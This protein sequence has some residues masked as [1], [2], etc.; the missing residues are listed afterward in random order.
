[1]A[2][3][4]KKLGDA[5]SNAVST[6]K[7][8]PPDE[9]EANSLAEQQNQ[10]NQL[11]AKPTVESTVERPAMVANPLVRYGT[12]P[13]EVRYEV[14][15]H[16]NITPIQSTPAR[17]ASAP[18][19]ARVG[20][21]RQEQPAPSGLKPIIP[22]SLSQPMPYDQG[23]EKEGPPVRESMTV[24][25]GKPSSSLPPLVQE[26]KPEPTAFIAKS[27]PVYDKGGDVS[28][29]AA[30]QA[31]VAGDAGLQSRLNE[32]DEQAARPAASASP[33][34]TGSGLK[35]LGKAIGD[36]RA[37]KTSDAIGNVTTDT[38]DDVKQAAYMPGGGPAE[39]APNMPVM[40][41]ASAPVYDEGGDVDVN[42]G[43]HQAAILKEGEKVLTPEQAAQYRAEHEG[44]PVDFPGPVLPN[45]TGIKVHDSDNP[46]PKASDTDRLPKG[47]KA[48]ISNAPL[49][50]PQGDV[51]NPP[52]AD[53]QPSQVQNVSAR[54]MKPY[55]QVIE[56]RAKAKAEEK[57][58]SPGMQPIASES[59]E[60]QVKE[61]PPEERGTPQERAAIQK[62]KQ[63]A[64]G[65]G[66]DG[67]VKLG[68]ALIHQ[69]ALSPTPK[70]F[71]QGS[72]D[73]GTLEQGMAT[74][75]EFGQG[76]APQPG[77]KPIGGAPTTAAPPTTPATPPVPM[78][79]K[80]TLANY[81]KEIQA[82]M[83]QATPE[84]QERA[85]LLQKAKDNYL[86]S[87]PYGS[88][89]NH[90]GFLGKLGHVASK[91]GNIA[92]DV[93]APGVMAAIPGTDIYKAGGLAAHNQAATSAIDENT[94]RQAE[95]NKPEKTGTGPAT[96]EQVQDY[97]QRIANSGLSGPALAT[98]GKAPAGS[99]VA[100]LDK[101]FEEATKLRGMNQ[102]D[103]DTKIAE[104]DRLDKAA[105]T[106][107]QHGQ[108]RNDKLKKEFY[109]YTD[110]KGTHVTTGDK[111]DDIPD[112]VDLVPTKDI[113]SLLGEGR[114]MNAVQDSM[115]AI[116]KDLDEHPEVFNNAAARAIV[117]TTTEQMNRAAAGILIAGTGGSIPLPSGLGDMI[118][119][120]L[121]NGALD[122]KTSKAV[123]N[124]IADYKAMKDKAM[125]I[126]MNMQNG[127]MGRGGQQAFS[128]IVD[129]MPGGSTPDNATALRQMAALQKTSSGLMGKYP[130]D[131][132]DYKKSKPYAAKNTP[133]PEGATNEVHKSKTDN[134][135]IGHMVNGTYVPLEQ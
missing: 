119:T 54:G 75:K 134:T 70:E 12:Q 10:I 85:A 120:A 71:N 121:Q 19:L 15:A 7:A 23:V 124:Y 109:T 4:L 8:M 83:D 28:M 114:A 127:K 117:Q 126:Q 105:E 100:E 6:L 37:K 79:H 86:K 96:A 73:K 62:D 61:T 35:S 90:P 63:D 92:G 68:T 91:L 66:V 50:T 22:S 122:D 115:N 41:M 104:Q 108:V 118:N 25:T 20:A 32:P 74:P 113:G 132:A 94:K 18:A 36:Y 111:L 16:G 131:Y 45:P 56:D 80:A 78:D 112:N 99:T 128:S 97:Q 29:A 88:A 24:D 82:A 102:K 59:T 95:E 69:N 49:K 40:P 123:K 60:A 3:V 129:Q 93:I 44:A 133:A 51:S 101:R 89:T 116:H 30:K 21:T 52:A 64:M 9:N 107:F 55:S 130:D 31:Q 13:G 17:T 34:S 67:F 26:V 53:V 84:G 125:V 38:G 72:E 98:Y 65:Q 48:D 110:D 11:T 77:L 76:A 106:K 1:M 33:T 39:A 57:V 103:A 27:A 81:D 5:A 135:V 47:V 43:Q 58:Q 87:T 14:D 42:D 46:E 2:N